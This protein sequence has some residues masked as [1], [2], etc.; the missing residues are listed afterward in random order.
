VSCNAQGSCHVPPVVVNVVPAAPEPDGDITGNTT[1][2]G[3][4]GK[5]PG[6]SGE[7]G[8]GSANIAQADDAPAVNNTTTKAA[9]V[10]NRNRRPSHTVRDTCLARRDISL[11][12]PSTRRRSTTAAGVHTGAKTRSRGLSNNSSRK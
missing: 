2:T 10:D 7:S 3:G 5:H 4:T 8:G 12:S 6:G 11:P 9:A 1:F